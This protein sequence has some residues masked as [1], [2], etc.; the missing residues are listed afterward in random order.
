MKTTLHAFSAVLI[1]TMCACNEPAKEPVQAAIDPVVAS[2]QMDYS[3]STFEN[4]DSTGKHLGYGYDIL[5]GSK[6]MIHQTTI[7]G[8]P[9]INGFVSAEEAERVARLVLLKL[10]SNS[11]FPT[12]NRQE[13]DSLKI[14]LQSETK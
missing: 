11:G 14:T 4:I 12:I 2:T 3:L 13:L 9:G 1:A 5:N 6:R 8:E 10:E 7:P